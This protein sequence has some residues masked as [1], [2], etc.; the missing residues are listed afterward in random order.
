[1]QQP[2]PV[3]SRQRLSLESFQPPDGIGMELDAD[4]AGHENKGSERVKGL[5]RPGKGIKKCMARQ[6][7][8]GG[9]QGQ[10]LE[11]QA[12]SER[13]VRVNVGSSNKIRARREYQF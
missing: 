9:K 11:W 5:G 10:G 13:Q 7:L 4:R 3:P 6:I 2:L 8:V 12:N 1:M